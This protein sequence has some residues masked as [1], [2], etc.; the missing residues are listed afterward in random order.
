MIALPIEF[1]ISMEIGMGK[2][3]SRLIFPIKKPHVSVWLSSRLD[4]LS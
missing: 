4:E 1:S 3:G 2:R